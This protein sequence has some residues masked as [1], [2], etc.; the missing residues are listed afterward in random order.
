MILLGFL[1]GSYGQDVIRLSDF[2]EAWLEND[3]ERSL[4]L[5]G[6]PRSS[7]DYYNMAFLRYIQGDQAGALQGLIRA[8]QLESSNINI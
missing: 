5:M 4:Q 1:T 3:P 7:A 8:E 2:E 6:Q